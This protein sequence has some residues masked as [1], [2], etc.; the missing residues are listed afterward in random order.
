MAFLEGIVGDARLALRALRA[1]PGFT[2]TV[3]LSLALAIGASASAYSVVDAIRF[4]ALPFADADRLVLISEAPVDGP[5]ASGANVCRAA[6]SVAFTTYRNA[7]SRAH[8]RTMDAIAAHVSGIKVLSRDGESDL[9]LGTLVTDS[10]FAMLHATPA[11]GRAFIAE[12]HRLGAAPVVM[13]SNDLWTTRFGSDRGILGTAIQLSDTRYTVV[14]VMPPG[15][16]FEANT[17]FWLPA[18]PSLD[19]STR[20][21]IRSV[22]VIGRLAP[23]MT[24][25]QASAE[26]IALSSTA[27]VKGAAAPPG[28]T[29][30]L[31][32]VASPL[33]DRYTTAA[34]N[35]DV[36]FFAIVLGVVLIACFNLTNLLL[37][38]ALD[39]RREFA[40]RAALGAEP[41]QLVRLMLVQHALLAAAGT[42]L[43]LVF[44]RMFLAV[45]KSLA[46]L[47]TL[48][49]SGMDY[50]IDWRV[51][52]FAA[53]LAAVAAVVMSIVPVRLV[54]A[55]RA[56]DA[57]RESASTL[58]AGHGGARIQRVFVTA[59]VAFAVTLL[60]SAGLTVR[61]VL[62]LARVNL[63]FTAEHLVQVT[64]SLPHDW[65]E[66]AK[67]VP[68][69]ERIVET[70]RALPGALSMATRATIPLGTARAP[71]TLTIAGESAPLTRDVSPASV[72]A[73]DSGYFNTLGIA[74]SRGR[75]FTADDGESS[76][77]VA[78][79]NEW[80]ANRWF[81]GRDAIGAQV[82]IDT[83]PGKSVTVTIVG[84]AR[85][86]KAGRG[87]LLLATDGPELYRPILQASSAFPTF[88]VRASGNPATL[89]RPMRSQLGQIVLGRPVIATIMT[90]S[91]RQ[92]L[93]GVESTSRQIVAFA[94]VGLVLALVGVYG[95][96][97]YSVNKRT[98]EL[99]IRRA[100]G[101]SAPNV[102]GLIV[103]D[104]M[105][106]AVPGLFL[107]ALGALYT[108]RFAAPLLYGTPQNDPLT[109]VAIAVVVLATAV[110]SAIVPAMRA[111]RVSPMTALRNQ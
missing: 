103:R 109:F 76:L 100:L 53:G 108:G 35:N 85:D 66:K 58:P 8:L 65:R 90:E 40:V 82:R 11:V 71:A 77:P 41:S 17:K 84:V 20:P 89:L 43:G 36:I 69:T 12:D 101:A 19:P 94:V 59:Q 30:Q 15:F 54:L 102:Y 29:E 37:T 14:G 97:A 64:P 47:N 38:R 3:T 46:A 26:L 51:A 7:L 55:A 1:N 62:R 31:R 50:R 104:A 67:Y 6:C 34:Q 32:L 63:G 25:A 79:V 106:V 33:R 49:P 10:V 18:V 88:F 23:G 86:N 91:V 21:S 57:L 92:Q 48:R 24:I 78:I 9:L 72:L 98:R 96:L 68:A 16:D 2:A 93:E 45:V 110:A 73:V 44:A 87:S 80:A 74:V 99:G 42:A 4:R 75:A 83:L 13:L 56:Q 95:V 39:Q 61:T 111:S 107:G 70:L 28:S 5:A 27:E 52:L 22:T 81:A 105:M 60:V